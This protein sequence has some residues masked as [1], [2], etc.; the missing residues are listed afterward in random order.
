MMCGS[1]LFHFQKNS[2]LEENPNANFA[3]H[4]AFLESVLVQEMLKA[5]PFLPPKNII[6]E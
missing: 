4:S 3:L 6:G 2:Y 1:A 5:Q